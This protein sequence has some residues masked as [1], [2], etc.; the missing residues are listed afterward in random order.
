MFMPPKPGFF[1]QTVFIK[2]VTYKDIYLT[3]HNDHVKWLYSNAHDT[4]EQIEVLAKA[5]LL[6]GG[7]RKQT[8]LF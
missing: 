1:V 4:D 3:L 2:W 8:L 7:T 5:T 6:A